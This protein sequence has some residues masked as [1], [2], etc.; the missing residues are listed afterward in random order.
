MDAVDIRINEQPDT[1]LLRTF[2]LSKLD[3]YEDISIF[4]NLYNIKYAD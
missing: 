1:R 3:E 4:N 2:A